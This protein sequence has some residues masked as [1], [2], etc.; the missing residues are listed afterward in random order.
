MK[1]YNSLHLVSISLD[2]GKISK[3]FLSLTWNRKSTTSCVTFFYPARQLSPL[4]LHLSWSRGD[5]KELPLIDLEQEIHTSCVIALYFSCE[6]SSWHL[7]I[8]WMP[9]GK[10]VGSATG[11][12]KG[13]AGWWMVG[14]PAGA[15]A[16]WWFVVICVDSGHDRQ[17]CFMPC[18]ELRAS[19]M[20]SGQ[21]SLSW[22]KLQS[23]QLRI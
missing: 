17:T 2:H 1:S 11:R 22:P 3:R 23:C 21:V 8:A 16:C 15:G 18:W 19:C 7:P 13:W 12:V 14:S 10:D 9:G 5:I 20:V 4:S 6:L